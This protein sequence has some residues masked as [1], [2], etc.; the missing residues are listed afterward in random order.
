[1]S[2]QPGDLDRLIKESEEAIQRLDAI[3]K[4]RHNAPL[5]ERVRNHF[6]RNKAQVTNLLLA[7][8]VLAVAMGRLGQKQEHEVGGRVCIVQAGGRVAGGMCRK[9]QHWSRGMLARAF[10]Q[11]LSW[12]VEHACGPCI[13]FP[14]Q[15]T[16]VVA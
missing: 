13:P 16:C 8:T 11:W 9:S 5:L 2:G 14:L 1:M 15:P 12:Q 6:A 4:A 3:Q 7:G 10:A